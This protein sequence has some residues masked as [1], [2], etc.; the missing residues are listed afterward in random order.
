MHR[1][2]RTIMLQLTM[3]ILL[4]GLLLVGTLTTL[5]MAQEPNSDSAAPTITESS[6]FEPLPQISMT[7]PF[8]YARVITDEVPIYGN[9]LS[10]TGELSPTHSLGTGYLWVSLANSQPLTINNQSWYQINEDEFVKME[11]VA[12]YT[13]SVFHGITFTTPPTQPF[14]F[15]VYYVRPSITPGIV[16]TD[17]RWLR[18]YNMVTISETRY[19]TD[20][21]WYQVGEN[22]WVYDHNLGVVTPMPRPNPI[23]PYDKWIEVNLYEQTLAVYEGD[24]LV[25]ATLVSSGLPLWETEKGLF[26]LERK[27]KSAKMSGGMV[28]DD[29]YF[30]EDVPWT[31]YFVGPY[32]LHGAYW[33]DSFGFPH[34]HGCVNMSLSDSQWLFEW[35]TPKPSK[36]NRISAT[37]SNPGTWVFVHDGSGWQPPQEA[38]PEAYNRF[39]FVQN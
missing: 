9:P 20:T 6:P 38:F 11:H 36:Y 4:A 17:T 23:G 3:S 30:V 39:E 37:E 29:Y 26:R 1:S 14:G 10:S 27:I 15:L 32:A 28:G 22:Q 12:L 19:I 21:P 25:F 8:S 5:T 34:S 18:R 16:A 13:P 24:R 31:M 7:M 2:T 35:S 33:H